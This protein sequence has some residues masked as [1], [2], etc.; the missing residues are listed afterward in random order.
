MQYT[1]NVLQI[2]SPLLNSWT[3]GASFRRKPCFTK[4]PPRKNWL[5]FLTDWHAVEDVDESL[6]QFD[7]VPALALV[8]EAINPASE[9]EEES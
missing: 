3:N 8:I 5:C 9:Q 4:A 6:P 2:K 7:A 1:F